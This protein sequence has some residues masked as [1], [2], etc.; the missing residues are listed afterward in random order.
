M[1][2]MKGLGLGSGTKAWTLEEVRRREQEANREMLRALQDRGRTG[3]LQGTPAIRVDGRLLIGGIPV[4]SW[5]NTSTDTTSVTVPSE[6]GQ[7]M[8]IPGG[9]ERMPVDAN[10]EFTFEDVEMLQRFADNA[11]AGPPKL[12]LQGMVA[13]ANKAIWDAEA[14]AVEARQP[15]IIPDEPQTPRQEVKPLLLDEIK[16]G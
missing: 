8:Q 13:K 11:P 6:S 4:G 1:A 7:W 3:I 9:A 16:V 15:E 2:I 10:L 5:I 14:R 12:W